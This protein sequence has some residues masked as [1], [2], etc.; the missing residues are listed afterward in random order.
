MYT[1][2]IAL[3]VAIHGRGAL[4][5]LPASCEAGDAGACPAK[6]KCP[7]RGV[8]LQ[9]PKTGKVWLSLC[10][11][12]SETSSAS[13]PVTTT[14]KY[15]FTYTLNGYPW[16]QL[17]GQWP[18]C[19]KSG[20]GNNS[21]KVEGQ[22]KTTGTSYPYVPLTGTD[23]CPAEWES[24]R[25]YQIGDVVSENETVYACKDN[26]WCKL[27]GPDLFG[28]GALYWEATAACEGTVSPTAAPTFDTPNAG[29]PD[30]YDSSVAYGP[31]DKIAVV[32][33]D[34]QIVVYQCKSWPD[35]EFCKQ[36]IYSPESTSLAC[37]GE[38]C[39]SKAWVRVGGCEGTYSPTAAPTFDTAGGCPE[40]YVA[41][42]PYE[43][44][45]KVS[46][47]GTGE[48]QGKIYQCQGWPNAGHCSTDA[49]KPGSGGQT[50]NGVPLWKSAW[51]YVGGCEGTISPTSSPTFSGTLGGCPEE[52]DA[53]TPY[54]P[55][56][57]VSV[58]NQDG[59]GKI[60]KCKGWPE[61]GQC[62]KEAYRP[63]GSA[64]GGVPGTKLWTTAWSYVGGC[65]GTISP[66]G[67]PNFVTTYGCPEE[68]V[69]GTEY[70]E[71]DKVSIIGTGETQG[72]IYKCKGWPNTGYCANDA[73]R[74]GPG[75]ASHDGV[76]LWKT[77]WTYVG[78]CEGTISPT[79][80]PMFNRLSQW[81]GDGCPQEYVPNNSAY[82]P[83]DFVSV[84]KNGDNTL[85][86]VYQ[87]KMAM[88]SPWCQLEGYAPGTSNGP[89]A[90]EKVGYCEG[91][92]SPTAAPTAFTGVC[93][94][95][96]KIP[97][98]TSGEFVVLQ[99]GAWVKGPTSIAVG[100]GGVPLPLY[101]AGNLV[102]Y[103]N[104][105]RK[106]S[107]Y[108]Y[109]GYCQSY[110]PFEQ[111]TAYFNPVLS[112]QG[113]SDVV[114]AN[115]VTELD[116]TDAFVQFAGV[117]GAWTAGGPVFASS[118]TP[119]VNADGKCVYD[120][121]ISWA[122]TG[123]LNPED[124]F[125]V[126]PAVKPCQKCAA[127]VSSSDLG[128]GL[129]S[130]SAPKVCTTCV[131]GTKSTIVNQR[132]VCV[133]TNGAT[134]PWV[135]LSTHCKQCSGGKRYIGKYDNTDGTGLCGTCPD[136]WYY[137]TNFKTGS[138]TGEADVCCKYAGCTKADGTTPGLK[139]DC[140]DG[141]S[142]RTVCGGAGLV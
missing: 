28:A 56:D 74:P 111:N 57:K 93:Q 52:Y 126:N 103:G 35:G 60:Y 20:L 32:R 63:G 88:T 82:G 78:G 30:E 108:P 58:T 140:Y 31:G 15:C 97:T 9:P 127:Y 83:G 132:S 70:E 137:V 136:R 110:S 141:T 124:Y 71:G 26:G 90:W 42:T 72:K 3:F 77:A 121:G 48:T 86:I 128:K 29:C 37:G 24:G 49:Y 59:M 79:T 113:W 131:A 118:G 55:G 138:G 62:V 14:K 25:A 105:A 95:K 47:I 99:A 129:D 43:A 75:G 46:I 40:E 94:Y 115:V 7:A 4:A 6:D 102:R 34:G 139:T 68:Y 117:P 98:S 69:A 18:T 92:M 38:K 104:D 51:T 84:P 109:N 122:D 96:Y 65:T 120:D 87:C 66:T 1:K 2:S 41:G 89:Q 36:E 67:A 114:C 53:G 45:D 64:E 22:C 27:T 39:W 11:T 142:G 12:D 76:P 19:N 125:K 10:C 116:V 23:G 123:A 91:T 61:G 73:Y 101:Q 100:G 44:G 21:W 130:T 8:E 13:P 107:A 16:N 106:C 133:C 54:Q 134:N 5:A 17:H 33:K 50:Y 135:S 80:S 85:G 119:L 81:E 112:K